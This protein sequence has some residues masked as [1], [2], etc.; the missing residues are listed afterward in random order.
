MDHQGEIDASE[1][2]SAPR[3]GLHAST[4]APELFMGV[5]RAVTE[6]ETIPDRATLLR[7]TP[8]ILCANTLF[9]RVVVSLVE[10]SRLALQCLRFEGSSPEEESM[11][12]DLWNADPP[13]LTH[14]LVESEVIR[15]NRAILVLDAP[16]DARTISGDLG[17]N[18]NPG[19]YVAAP[20]TDGGGTIGMVHADRK[21]SGAT[22]GQAEA[23]GLWLFCQALSLATQRADLAA[24][25]VHQRDEVR[26]HMAA[27]DAALDSPRAS[28]GGQNAALAPMSDMQLAA[29]GVVLAPENRIAS[30]LTA[31]EL[32]VL[33]LMAEGRTNADIAS[34]LVITEGT[35]KSHVKHVLRK[36]RAGNR[37]EA[38]TRYLRIAGTE[39]ARL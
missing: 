12:R 3:D 38:V 7:R 2:M 14:L 35:V 36:L 30:L 27:L 20:L 5:R 16:R 17:R 18:M 26:R 6:L 28:Y 4:A 39:Q 37:V 25:L 33:R 8:E 21:A 1:E 34:C 32:D 15:R 31:R 10:D 23:D 19:S 11:V 9:E 29:A 13:K 24:R 22:V